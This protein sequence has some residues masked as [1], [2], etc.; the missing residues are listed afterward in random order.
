MELNK[1]ILVFNLKKMST[2]GPDQLLWSRIEAALD[3]DHTDV[4]PDTLQSAIVDLPQ[5]KA[6]QATWEHILPTLESEEDAVLKSAI[7]KLPQYNAPT[8]IWD[9]IVQNLDN[10]QQNVTDNRYLSV[11]KSTVYRFAA[12]AVMLGFILTSALW[13]IQNLPEANTSVVAYQET[14]KTTTE[15]SVPISE[16]IKI[17]AV[18]NENKVEKVNKFCEKQA[19][20][21]EQPDFQNLKSQLEELTEAKKELQNAIGEFNTDEN[22]VA[23]LSDIE[24]E[25]GEILKK[26]MTKI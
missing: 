7:A 22:L 18:E 5:Y 14:T 19:I 9:S 26:L 20:V 24:E 1:D 11:R 12:A 16:P 23:Q 17:A 6:P 3:E 8:H 15:Q 13:Y 4:N 25:R 2:Y 21:C 10:V